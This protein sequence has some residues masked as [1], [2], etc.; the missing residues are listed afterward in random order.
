MSGVL[1]LLLPERCAACDALLPGPGVFCEPCESTVQPV[2]APWCRVCAEPG[3][4]DGHLCQRCLRE[5]PPFVKARS[6]F[7][8]EGAIA[9]A[10]QRFK[11]AD[12]PDLSRQLGQLLASAM[13][14]EL[15]AGAVVVP[16]PLH[17]ERFRSRKFDQAALLAVEV[18]KQTGLALREDLLTRVR[19]TERQVGLSEVERSTNL[20]GAFVAAPAAKGH[21]VVLV[22]DV[23]TTGA[24]ASEATRAFNAEG[25]QV[26]L[27][28]TLGR[29]QRLNER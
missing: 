9:K 8:H 26:A 15:P 27:V 6:A 21:T 20:K 12:R 29:M 3:V 5:V 14:A 19:H 2:E 11:Y 22:D 28:L 4:A 10:V 25:A 24:T 16:I 1:E 18:A 23:Y 7:L 17:L 13:K